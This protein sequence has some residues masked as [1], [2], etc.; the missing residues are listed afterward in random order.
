MDQGGTSR[1]L[2]RAATL[3]ASLLVVAGC[4]LNDGLGAPMP[5]TGGGS[6]DAASGPQWDSVLGRSYLP[7]PPGAMVDSNPEPGDAAAPPSSGAAPSASLSSR[8][9]S[10]ARYSAN[11][12][13]GEGP[14]LSPASLTLTL[15]VGE[16]HPEHKTASIPGAPPR[17]DVVFAIDLT[18]S[19]A[20]ELA[21]VKENSR[22]IM[23]AVNTII[24]DTRYGVVS[25]MDYPG[26]YGGC[27]YTLQPY[28]D[29]A[30]GDYPYSLDRALTGD[31]AS[32]EAAIY[33]LALGYGADGPESYARVLYESYADPG[34][35][36]QDGARRILLFWH[37][38]RVS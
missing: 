30:R 12:T 10:P 36:W 16:S 18:G 31:L 29:A 9:L 11:S 3:L 5:V 14:S 1:T 25:H 37:L 2:S 23:A 22:D 38:S 21:K 17:G 34:I 32:V 26:T 15:R 35:G 24:P 6:A 33:A 13:G 4:N 27:G 20:E 8:S 7:L 19:M 28:G